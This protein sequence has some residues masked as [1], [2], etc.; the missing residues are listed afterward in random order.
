MNACINCASDIKLRRENFLSVCAGVPSFQLYKGLGIRGLF[1]C[2]AISHSWITRLFVSPFFHFLL[3]LFLYFFLLYFPL[4]LLVLCSPPELVTSACCQAKLPPA[5]TV[6][7]GGGGRGYEEMERY[8]DVVKE[9]EWGR[10]R[11]T[12]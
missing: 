11:E 7:R 1:S 9:R 5:G 4:S 3:F 6:C 2:L 8:D 10:W 12:E